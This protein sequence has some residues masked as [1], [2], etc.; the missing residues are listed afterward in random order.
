[1]KYDDAMVVCLKAIKFAKELA[2]KH[3]IDNL[4][5]EFINRK[6]GVAGRAYLTKRKIKLNMHHLLHNKED[7]NNTII[8]EVAHI[9][10][11]E[12]FKDTGHGTAWKYICKKIGGSGKRCHSY[13]RVAIA[14][15]NKK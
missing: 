12:A 4:E 8:H 14:V 2:S 1:M 9:I 3:N 13:S 10:A 15:E 6:S 11:Y 5:V 7:F